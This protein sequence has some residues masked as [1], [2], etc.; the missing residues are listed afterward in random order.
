MNMMAW[1]LTICACACVCCLKQHLFSLKF[2]KVAAGDARVWH[3]DVQ[4]F[5]AFDE[6]NRFLGTFYLDLHVKPN[7][8]RR[9]SFIA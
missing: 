8:F 9:S 4:Q 1:F 2:V 5:N 6:T 7:D 3:A